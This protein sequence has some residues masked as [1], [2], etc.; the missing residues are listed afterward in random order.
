MD[1]IGFI[2][3][4]IDSEGFIHFKPLGGFD[5]KTLTSLRV[6]VHG[7]KKSLVGVMGCKPIH[8]MTEEER[9]RPLKLDDYFIDL[10][11]SKSK[12]EKAGIRAGSSI[13]RHQQTIKMGDFINGKSLDNRISCYLLIQ[14][15]KQ[16]GD[17]PFDVYA[18][19]T[20]QEEVGLRGAK[21]AAHRVKPDFAIALDVTVAND[22]SGTSEKDHVTRLGHGPAIKIIDGSVIC[23]YRM[24]DFLKKTAE[25]EKIKWQSEILP[26]GGTD[27]AALQ[28]MSKEGAI[29]G[30]ISTPLR[31]MHQTSETIHP[32]DVEGGIGLLKKALETLDSYS[33]E[34][35]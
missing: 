19:F 9:K 14:A 33:W 4:H 3:S 21:V 26:F 17:C 30:A 2:V 8:I 34:H 12:I 7:V 35:K 22:V 24:V 29:A 10:G 31:Y 11:L 15:F 20:V 18:T 23:D 6:E 27:T 28:Q 25:A 13:T 5:P 16:L 1:E 32:K